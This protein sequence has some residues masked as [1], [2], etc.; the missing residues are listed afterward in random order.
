[1]AVLFGLI[2]GTI[3]SIIIQKTE[4]YKLVTIVY[5]IIAFITSGALIG[6]MYLELFWV[7]V[8]MVILFGFF[9]VGMIPLYIDFACEVTFPMGEAMS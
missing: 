9:N 5:A 4:K 8:I 2:G 3:G 6:T 1:M 7:S